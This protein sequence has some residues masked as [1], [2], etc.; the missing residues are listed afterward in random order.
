[1]RDM[2]EM[3]LF[4]EHRLHIWK[5]FFG[6]SD[7]VM[8]FRAVLDTG[9][10]EDQPIR[11]DYADH[12]TTVYLGAVCLLKSDKALDLMAFEA[13]FC[14][15]QRVLA[16]LSVL[17]T[18]AEQKMEEDPTF[19]PS[20]EY[21]EAK[22]RQEALTSRLKSMAIYFI[23]STAGCSLCDLERRKDGGSISSPVPELETCVFS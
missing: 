15:C 16:S 5:G 8:R 11:L 14:V 4:M 9:P 2:D 10:D 23:W 6:L 19:A 12:G 17:T 20:S 21:L 3:L 18:L 13:V 1:M 7:A 22:V